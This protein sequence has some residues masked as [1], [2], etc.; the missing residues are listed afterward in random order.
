[1]SPRYEPDLTAVAATLEQFEKGDFEFG[2]GE[3]KSFQ[4]T[5][6]KG[7]L[8]V[9]VRY[10][11][12]LSEESNGHKKGAKQMFSCYIHTDGGMTFSK[13]FIMAALGFKNTSQ[14]ERV[15]DE[16]YKGADWSIDPETGA[17]GDV[18]RQPAGRRITASLDVGVNPNTG[19]PSQQ[20]TGFAPVAA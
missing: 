1:M 16:K 7:Q 15:F 14:D 9:G 11:L 19:E 5:N 12:A 10:P 2:I 17:V 4:R 20:Y 13:R 8:S 3:P 18:W 6:D